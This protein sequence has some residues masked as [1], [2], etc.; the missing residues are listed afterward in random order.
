[1]T[2]KK[3]PE[4]RGQPPIAPETPEQVLENAPLD[5]LVDVLAKVS[6]QLQGKQ[7]AELRKHVGEIK[8]QVESVVAGVQRDVDDQEM[9]KAVAAEVEKLIDTVSRTGTAV[10]QAVGNQREAITAV[11]R[12]VELDKMADGLRLFADYLQDPSEERASKLQALIAQ[13]QQTM[14]H[15]VGYDP[16]R[17]E[18]ERRAAIKR[19]VKAS[20]DEI[21]R[22][23]KKPPTT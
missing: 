5:V 14:G 12:G 8:T 2:K 13:L 6:G 10:G 3:P 18:A 19:D 23:K 22:G 20:L 15:L 16:E 11:F 1:M 21:F 4:D 7:G 17:E 9:R